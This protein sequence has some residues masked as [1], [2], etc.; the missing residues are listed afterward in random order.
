MTKV[1]ICGVISHKPNVFRSQLLFSVAVA[2]A[3]FAGLFPPRS[4]SVS[5]LFSLLVA[6]PG[7]VKTSEWPGSINAGAK[8]KK[9]VHFPPSY[10][11]KEEEK[12]QTQA[13]IW[14]CP[15]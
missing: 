14:V 6:P 11:R 15:K 9:V 2:A 5:P 3:H 7:A 12:T 13:F 10:V 1:R 8:E 4:S